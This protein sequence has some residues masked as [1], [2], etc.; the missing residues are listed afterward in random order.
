MSE[1]QLVN[2]RPVFVLG[3]GRCG[4]TY[5]QK[6][7]CENSSIWIWGEHDGLLTGLFR[8]FN[9]ARESNTLNN[10]SYRHADKD[11][12]E[13]L[14]DGNNL[15]AWML[16]FLPSDLD[17]IELNVIMEL[18]AQSLPSGYQR[19][20]FKE[21][22]YGPESNVAS[23]L[24]KLFPHCKIIHLVRDPFANVDSALRAWHS[25][26]V[27]AKENS[28]VEL[29]TKLE[30]A[31]RHHLNRWAN[32]TKYYL[33]L[34]KDNPQQ[35]KTYKIELIQNETDNLFRFIEEQNP[36]MMIEDKWTNPTNQSPLSNTT[37]S[38]YSQWFNDKTRQYD[39]VVSELTEAL[40]YI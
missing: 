3:V 14:A 36:K 21:I 27:F 20:G 19:W 34:E 28:N 39:S 29:E 30:D 8:F 17:R 6:L 12:L 26:L 4:S 37:L 5:V 32:A 16:P 38:I 2:H 7:I 25:D 33:A 1:V 23:R 40:G 10:F 13:R 31:F 24:I 11:P 9:S 22:R 18:F 35:V 15:T